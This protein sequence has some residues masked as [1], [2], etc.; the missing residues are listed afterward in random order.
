MAK[1]MCSHAEE[2][3][4]IEEDDFWSKVK[5]KLIT[6]LVEGKKILDIGC[7]S[8]LISKT[9][10]EAGYDVTVIDSD[11]KAIDIAKK[12]GIKGFVADVN[13]WQTDEKFDC[14]IS[15][16]L[17]EH[18]DKDEALTKKIYSF[19]KPK[20]CFIVNVPSY[21]FLFGVHDIS[22]GHKRRYSNKE[23]RNKLKNSG[24]KIELLRHWNLLALP[25]TIVV[26]KIYKR[27]YP[28]ERIV[29]LRP[30]SKILE[31]LLLLETKTNYL[32]GISILC[33]ARK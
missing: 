15:A 10:L 29:R 22:L 5:V 31:N 13:N 3:A 14:I 8:G 1:D 25:F 16:D 12:K 6:G 33:K 7:G 17:L 20:G 23:I 11:R 26:T 2:L 9:L 21:Q 27:D 4:R 30:L 19:L 24:F 18:I 28:H 32:F